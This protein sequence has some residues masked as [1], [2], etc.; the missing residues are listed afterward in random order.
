MDYKQKAQPHPVCGPQ[1]ISAD[2]GIFPKPKEP[3]RG[4]R[5]QSL[6]RLNAAVAELSDNVAQM[7]S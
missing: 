2:M 4:Q 6:E 5:Y 3:L 1:M 7:D